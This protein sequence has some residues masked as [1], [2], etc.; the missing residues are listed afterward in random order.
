MK[1]VHHEIILK[2]KVY[3]K[4]KKEDYYFKAKIYKRRTEEVRNIDDSELKKRCKKELESSKEKYMNFTKDEEKIVLSQIRKMSG[5]FDSSE[6][7]EQYTKDLMFGSFGLWYEFQFESPYFSRDDDELYVV[8][9]PM[10]KEQI[11]KIPMIRGSSWKGLLSSVALDKLKEKVESKD[12][13]EIISCY[14]NFVRIFGTGSENFREAEKEIE[15]IIEEDE[16]KKNTKLTE[17]LF[18]YCV[19]D[20]GI[21]VNIQKDG[22]NIN[23]QL[24][25]EIVKKQNK[26]KV[27]DIFSVG[28]GRAIFYPTYLNKLNYEVIN[29]HSRKNRAGRNPIMY[30]VVPKGTKG[31][32]QLVYIPYDG[33]LMEKSNLEDEMKSDKEF[34]EE[35]LE[36]ALENVGIGAKTKLGW[37]R[38]K[39][40]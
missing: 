14:S 39:L 8:Q 33:I 18:E 31:I 30:E 5:I 7:L 26:E 11:S 34:I 2:D 17:K 29:P 22:T 13:K 10:L 1:K 23:K 38:G 37:G 25:D 16:K 24:I 36:E 4:H 28:K 15:K 27:K 21:D 12:I 20:L 3:G 32:F 6:E 19:F 35:I 9:N 40:L